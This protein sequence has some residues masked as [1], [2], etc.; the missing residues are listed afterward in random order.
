MSRIDFDAIAESISPEQLAQAIGARPNGGSFHCPSPN[1]AGGD[2]NPSLSINRKDGRTV[3]YCHSCGLKGTPVQ[4]LAEVCGLAHG[5]AA[6]RLAATAG[7]T[8]SATTMV[9]KGNG[10]GEEVAWYPYTDEAGVLLYEVVRFAFPKTFRPRLPDGTWSLPKS[11]RRVLFRLPE[12]IAGV[13]ANRHILVVEGEKDADELV[14]RDFVTTTCP[15]GAGKWKPEFSEILRGARVVILPDNDDPG[16]EHGQTIAQAL[17]GIASEVRVLDLPDLPAKGDVSDWFKA[18]GTDDELNA[19]VMSAPMWEPLGNRARCSNDL[20]E[21]F[22]WLEHPSLPGEPEPEP[23]P[24]DALPPVLRDMART[25]H[26]VTQAPLDSA[27]AVVLGGV[28]VAIVGKVWVEICPR[29]QWIKPA[30]E[31]VGIQQ[32]S[33]T[34]KSPLINMVQRPI[35]TW[36]AKKAS[37][38]SAKRRWAEEQIKLAEKC[39][40][41]L[42]KSAV[43]DPSRKDELKHA[44][45]GL[46]EAEREPHGEFQLLLSDATEEGIVRVLAGN[47]GRAASVDQEGTI[48]EV[49]SGRYGNG[50]ARLAALTHG[51]DGEPMRT[52]RASK[53]RV[54]LPSVSLALLLGLQPGI[55]KGMLNAETMQ[56]RGLLARFLWIAPTLRWDEILT[57]RNV[58]SLDQAAV[59]RYEEM[60][61]RLLDFPNKSDRSEGVPHLLKM[62]PEAQEGVYRLEQ[63]KV[64]GMRPGGPLQSVPAFAGKLPDHGARVAA[65]LTVAERAAR[66]ENP[67]HDPIPGWAMESA[68]RLI[69]V[70]STHVVKVTG[71][72][73]AD[74]ML[75]DLRYLLERVV[76]MEGSTESDIREKARARQSFRNALHAQRMFD[77]LEQRGF[78]RRILRERVEGPGRNPSPCIEVNPNYLRDSDLSDKSHQRLSTGN[79]S[80]KS[81]GGAEE[82]SEEDRQYLADERASIHMKEAPEPAE[83]PTFDLLTGEVV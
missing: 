70:I 33:G 28:S 39:V 69:S 83:N 62:S 76:E 67:F 52:N 14:Q 27:I 12:V 22:E 31:Y 71:D 46:M 13:E 24:L 56:Q 72:A 9:S 68:E 58:P 61:T 4:V 32:P 59:T 41:S 43:Q 44:L 77:E 15:G 25:S 1:H 38:E 66:G 7:V 17:E 40:D 6:E 35:A 78:I 23:L 21:P 36:E 11:V 18:G 20:A 16:R 51:W 8:S 48:L 10:L 45:D 81:D 80:E 37:E 50:D 60:L 64:D 47:G 2:K 73:G 57:G 30:H 19:L 54:D 3:A 34:G 29:R 65:L 5:D 55:L 79:R 75:S 82:L 63:A 49:A 26:E 74:P 42:R 53:A